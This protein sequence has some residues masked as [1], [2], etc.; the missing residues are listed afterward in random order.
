MK[1]T[2]IGKLAIAAGILVLVGMVWQ[3]DAAASCNR[4]QD[5]AAHCQTSLQQSWAN[6]FAGKSRST[7]FHFVDFL[8]LLNRLNPTKPVKS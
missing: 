2:H 6:W 3:L 5:Q 4:G 1:I 8:E 7:Q